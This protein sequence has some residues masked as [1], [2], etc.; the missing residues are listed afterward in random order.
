MKKI[1]DL[2]KAVSGIAVAVLI[3]I[4]A[5]R[6]ALKE[7]D[8]VLLCVLCVFAIAVF[9]L[10]FAVSSLEERVKNLE[11]TLGIYVDKGYCDGEIDKKTCKNC[12]AEIDIDYAVCPYCGSPCDNTE[13]N[14]NPYIE[15]FKAEKFKTEEAGYNGTDYSD[16]EPVSANFDNPD[17]E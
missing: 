10:T 6:A 8:I 2:F 15:K 17:G 11:D 7:G 3:Y 16:E 5:S 1:I 4:T 13:E 14:G 12:S 9:V